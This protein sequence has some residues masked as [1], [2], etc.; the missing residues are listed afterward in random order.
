[1]QKI[2]T[3]TWKQKVFHPFIFLCAII[4]PVPNPIYE[5]FW[6]K[7]DFYDSF[8]SQFITWNIKLFMQPFKQ[9]SFGDS[10]DSPRSILRIKRV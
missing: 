3:G 2:N 5:N 1:M 6:S 4:I 9:Q 8:R 7:A 10:L